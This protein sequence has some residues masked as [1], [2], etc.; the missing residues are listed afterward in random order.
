MVSNTDILAIEHVSKHFGGVR[1]LDNVSLSV[2]EGRIT[3]LI[4]PN[5]AGKTT[6]FNTVTGFAPADEGT[7]AFDGRRIE[8]LKPWQIAATGLARTFQTPAGFPT[9]S[10][11]ENLVVAGC[12]RET[13][14]LLAAF[15]GPRAWRAAVA[16]TRARADALLTRLDLQ[17][18]SNLPLENLSSV[19]TK[20]VEL[21]RQLMMEPRMLL[22]DEP[23]AGFGPDRLKRLANSVKALREGGM[24]V[25][26]VEHNLRF[27]LALADYVYVLATGRIISH[28]TPE[29]ITRDER[30]IDAYIGTGHEIA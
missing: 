10:V 11:W 16:E 6:L 8:R 12:T 4:G 27:V 15:A 29:A 7:I 17:H 18:L 1:A 13:E 22:L 9:L 24:A 21:G 28:G 3:A 2:T 26:V 25:L 20:L 23:A 5:G 30:V 14:S 19:D